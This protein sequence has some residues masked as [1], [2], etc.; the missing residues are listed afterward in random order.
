GD[1]INISS[2]IFN[3]L[4]EEMTVTLLTY[5]IEGQA[6][7]FHTA[8]VSQIGSGGVIGAR[9]SFEYSFPYTADQAGSFNINAELR[10]VIGGEE[11]TFT[12][13]LKLSVSD[14]SI[15]TKVLVDGT[16]YNDYVNG[17][18]SGNMTN[19]INMGTSDNIQVKIVQPGEEVTPEMLQDVA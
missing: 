10:A 7:P 19:F 12:D 14:P 4:S 3:N 5:T 11:Y 8:D 9:D 2:Q 16:H 17:Y 15:A 18:Y 13:V 6:E 1:E